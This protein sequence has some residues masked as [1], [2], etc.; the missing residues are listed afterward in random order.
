M[1]AGQNLI[2]ELLS[3]INVPK[4]RAM[5]ACL[6]EGDSLTTD[7]FMQ[8]SYA[9]D[10]I[11]DTSN[12]Y[13]G[14]EVNSSHIFDIYCDYRV[15][16]DSVKTR[17]DMIKYVTE[18]SRRYDWD[19]HLFLRLNNLSLETWIEKMSYW[20][21]NADTLSLYSLSD[22]CGI[23]TCVITKTKPWTTVDSNF[24]GSVNG[25]LDICQV[26]LLYLGE[27]KFRRLWKKVAKDTP[28]YLGVN[29]NYKPMLTL[30]PVP[31]TDELE[32]ANTLLN[33]QN[34]DLPDPFQLVAPPEF[35]GPEI[36][37][38]SD[39]MDKITGHFDVS[40]A[41]TLKFPDAMD[42]V[43]MT[44]N[45]T[46][47][48]ETMAIEEEPPLI[49]PQLIKKNKTDTFYV[50][51]LPLKECHVCITKLDMIL[52]GDSDAGSTIKQYN[53]SS[54]RKHL[55]R[56]STRIQPERKNRK[57]RKVSENIHYTEKEL[58][59]DDKKPLRKASRP[60]SKPA[61]DSPS[62]TRINSQKT[63]SKHP[64]QRLPPVPAPSKCGDTEDQ[65][66]DPPTATSLS[67]PKRKPSSKGKRAE[68]KIR[69]VFETKEHS[70][71]KTVKARK[72][73]CQMCKTGVN[74]AK[75]LLDHHI[76]KHGIVYC[77][78]CQKAFN[79]PLSLER[80]KYMHKEKRFM[81]STCNEGFQFM[82]QLRLHKVTH[83]R[84]SK[85]FCA[86]PGCYKQF[87]NKPDLNRH[88]KSHTSKE[89]RCPDCPYQ[90][91]DKRNFESHRRSH[92]RIERYFCE[93]CGKG[94]IYNTQK[95]HHLLK[96]AC[97]HAKK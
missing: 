58:S 38:N 34:T 48:V 20:A 72:Y 36:E 87:K 42:Q 63:R 12:V 13:W 22:M 73:R 24:K 93:I 89:T 62:I 15:H 69:G 4:L 30:P 75:E 86:Y 78:V 45:E 11:L 90:T 50:E 21:N 88:A 95:K 91:N 67:V 83:Q 59:E 65:T 29:Y 52:F 37:M 49:K 57:P 41:S 10:Y 84:R 39:A 47:H 23:H 2:S 55:T 40:H 1:V 26:K 27:N 7:D 64:N 3:A 44:D 43:V 51:T 70:L 61:T 68:L 56:S 25:V 82:S 32:V 74:S 6:S 17:L 19:G 60:K 80:H 96:K 9:T 54:S 77:P 92:S 46:L 28:S 16:R 71:K 76:D 97:K 18:N 94:F 33:M 31:S 53:D 8:S 79:N 85:H 66:T 5:P 81:C 14:G 35:F